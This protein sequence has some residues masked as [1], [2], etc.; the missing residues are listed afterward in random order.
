MKVNKAYACLT[1]LNHGSMRFKWDLENTHR[2]NFFNSIL[3][4]Q[5]K[6]VP[7]Q[8]SHSKIVIAAEKYTDT[9]NIFAD[10]IITCNKDLVP[11]VTVADCMP[12]YIF[13][14]ITGC[15]GVLHSGWKGT[16]IVIEALKLAKDKYNA[17]A[18]DFRIII[19]PHIKKC[20]YTVEK[21][22][23]ELFDKNISSSCIEKI[24]ENTFRLSLEEANIEIL[25]NFGIPRENIT[26]IGS[27]TNCTSPN[28]PVY[29]S[30]RRQ[31][32]SLDLPLEEKLQ[33]FTPM[34][35]FTY[36]G[37]ITKQLQDSGITIQ[38]L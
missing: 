4:P 38:E 19:G 5:K 25:K 10:G 7:L 8:L 32:S 13:D 2:N 22:R 36:F 26:I 16:G 28:N 27:C 29:G 30:F 14:P 11:I 18:Q 9:L 34:A 33:H 35:A 20:C 21:E 37:Q 15:F 23:A 17:K 31:T 3:E 1:L 12:I 6:L 24:D